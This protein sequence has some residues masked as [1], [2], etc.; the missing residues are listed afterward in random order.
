VLG[1]L[2]GIPEHRRAGDRSDRALYVFLLIVPSS[3]KCGTSKDAE[4]SLPV[5]HDLVTVVTLARPPNERGGV[6]RE[7]I[8]L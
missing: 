7:H 2:P 4:A 8:V 5:W 3:A 6:A 1:T